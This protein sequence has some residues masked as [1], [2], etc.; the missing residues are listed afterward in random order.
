MKTKT[1]LI[2]AAALAAGIISSQA[3]GVYSQNIVGYVNVPLTNGVLS[4]V[5]PALD[6]D[7]TGTN[8]TVASVFPTPAIGDTVYVF[9]GVGYTILNFKAEGSGHPV[10]LQTNWFEGVTIATNFPINPGEGVF[11]LP[12]ANET[13]TQVGTVLAGSTTNQFFP[14]A[15]SLGL[16]SSKIPISGGI[17]SVLGYQPTQ[18]DTLYQYAN[19]GY[20][21]FNYKAEG[22]GHPVVL[23]TN[24]FV[25]VT[26]EEPV[27]TVGSAFF[28]QP[29]SNTNWVE[30]L[31]VN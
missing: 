29:A 2:A 10:V 14:A 4:L 3:Q 26:E 30:T 28:F 24:W 27:I 13:N 11:Y 23:T 16:L 12:A 21:I 18:G 9:N 7:G 15:N 5:A 22:S 19:G 8:N 20:T 25:G 17:T 31:N 1:L 6:L